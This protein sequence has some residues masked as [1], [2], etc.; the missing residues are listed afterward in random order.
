VRCPNEGKRQLMH[1][2]L[3]GV[4]RSVL[5]DVG[6]SDSAIVTEARGLR[7][8]D[9]TRHGDVVVLDFFVEGRH[10][11]I[12]AVVTTVYRNN[13]FPHVATVPFYAAKQAEGHKFY[14]NRTSH[15]PIAAVHGSPHVLC[16]LRG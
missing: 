6:I 10:L 16:P 13:A 15:Q 1:G 12:D 11:A 8:A 2:G 3:V 9:A 7:S 5:K 4:I 14:A